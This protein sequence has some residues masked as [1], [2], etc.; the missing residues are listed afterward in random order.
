MEL[1]FLYSVRFN[2]GISYDILSKSLNSEELLLRLSKTNFFS[3]EKELVQP[4]YLSVLHI[5]EVQQ[6]ELTESGKNKAWTLKEK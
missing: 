2:G 1:K 4:K 6:L 3:I 5:V